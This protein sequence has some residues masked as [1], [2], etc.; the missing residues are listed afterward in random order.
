MLHELRADCYIQLGEYQKAIF[1]IRPTTKL[2]NDNTA[3]YMQLSTL[4]YKLG[5]SE[6]SLK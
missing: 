2:R 3:A 4:H 5:D 6:E 1:E